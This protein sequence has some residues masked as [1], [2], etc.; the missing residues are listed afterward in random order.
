MTELFALAIDGMDALATKDTAKLALVSAGI[1]AAL[2]P[3][4]A[5]FKTKQERLKM[6]K[7][8][9]KYFKTQELVPPEVYDLLGDMALNIF[10][11]EVLIDLDNL[12]KKWGKPLIINDW[13]QGGKFKFSGFRPLQ[14]SIGAP[15]SKHKLAKAF[16]L[17]TLDKKDQPAFWQFLANSTDLGVERLEHKDATPTWAHT[18]LGFRPPKPQKPYIFKP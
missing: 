6:S 9:P 13:H 2:A 4:L 10:D 14:C 15:M 18:E 11:D 12:R 1:I 16:D 3:L 5:K 17:K 7:Y 8:K